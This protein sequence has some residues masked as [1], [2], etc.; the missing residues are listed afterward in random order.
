MTTDRPRRSRWSRNGVRILAWLTG[1]ATFLFSGAVLAS[2]PK[3]AQERAARRH[4]P[5]P[6]KVIEHHV[7]RKVV[8][9]DPP[10]VS[11]GVSYV[12]GGSSSG[13][14]GSSGSTSSSGGSTSG[15]T[16]GSTGGTTTTTTGGSTGGGTTTTTTGGSTGGTTTTTTGG[17]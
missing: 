4:R 13:W 15:T 1:G 12:S 3:P 8:I 16:G 14:S 17:S 6:R 10:T 9:V 2:A 5:A 11:S 7:T